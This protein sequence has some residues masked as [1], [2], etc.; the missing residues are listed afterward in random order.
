MSEEK[1]KDDNTQ[2]TSAT[3]PSSGEPVEQASDTASQTQ[4][5]LKKLEEA[6]QAAGQYKD[7]LLRKAAD[8][9]NYKRR[10]EADLLNII[11]NANEDLM[12][13]LL[14]ILDDLARSLKAGKEQPDREAFYRGIELIDAKLRKTLEA[15]GLKPFDSVGKQFD[16]GYHDALLQIPRDDI[17]P[18]T[19]IEV[20]EQ[21]YMLKD[22]VLR[23]AKVI[24]S[25]TPELPSPETDRK[26]ERSGDGAEGGPSGTEID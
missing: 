23:H 9:E 24:V 13:N 6:E 21:G 8:F 22:R 3:E 12:Y 5:L 16:V 15:Q 19:V 26:E 4:E 7:Q 20:V 25:A 17:P 14:P 1:R 11:R 10:A 2:E 18:H